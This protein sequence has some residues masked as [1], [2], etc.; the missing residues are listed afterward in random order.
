MKLYIVKKKVDS[1]LPHGRRLQ[2]T[3]CEL[4][5]VQFRP[6][7]SPATTLTLSRL[8]TPSP[9]VLLQAEN[10]P[11]GPHWQSPN[12]KKHEM[13]CESHLYNQSLNYC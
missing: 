11:N 9:Q 10:A 3:S 13:S 1:L 8:L 7:G 2:D 5:P 6:P 12:D 4:G